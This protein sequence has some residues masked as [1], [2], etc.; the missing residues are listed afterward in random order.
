MD[1]STERKKQLIDTDH[2]DISIT[3]QAALL[4]ISR[5]TVY[6]RPRINLEDLELMRLI[7]EI[8]T[9]HPFYGAR[10]IR[11]L[12]QEMGRHVGRHRVRRLMR[13]MGLEAMYPKP[14]LSKRNQAHVIYPY[15]L[16][17][18]A[19]DRPN[20]VWS[21]DITYVRL[22]QGWVYVVAVM[23]WYSRYVLSWEVSTTLDSGFC[24]AALKNALQH[25]TPEIFN[26][27]Q[28][29]QFTADDFTSVL[30]ERTIQISMD[31]RGRAL[32]NVFT[33]R[34]WR[35]LKYEEVYL[36]EYSSVA[37]A[38]QAIADYFEFYNRSRPHQSLGYQTPEA[39]YLTL[40]QP[41]KQAA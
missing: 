3:R 35:S 14:N 41:A 2:P 36:H 30:K 32:D 37:E 13:L 20:Q 15:L 9:Q 17:N 34:L 29:S 4:G 16:R 10:K 31:G 27:D 24:V 19:I 6:Y 18:V 22:N 28:G 21:T 23:D 33:E 38:R 8:Y 26:T 25:G 40:N 12:L 1:W 5:S 39:I 11:H 7:D